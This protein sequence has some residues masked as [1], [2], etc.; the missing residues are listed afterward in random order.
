MIVLFKKLNIFINIFHNLINIIIK[1][2]MKKLLFRKLA[3][4]LILCF[5]LIFFV[6]SSFGCSLNPNHI[7]K[8]LSTYNMNLVFDETNF[9][10]NGN[11]Q[12]NFKNNTET[13]LNNLHFNLYPNAFRE[14]SNQKVI[15]LANKDKCYYNG[16]S[17]GSIKIEKVYD[18]QNDDLT[19]EVAGEDENILI[20]ELKN[21]V[22]PQ[23]NTQI[24]IS[25]EVTIP[26]ANH[27]FG[28]GENTV[29]LGNFFLIL[30]VYE[31]GCWQDMFYY[32]NGDPFY[33]E[34]SNFKVEIEY[35]NSYI[36]ASTG[37][38][39]DL[40]KKDD[41]KK[42]SVITAN[43][44]RDFAIVMSK[45]FSVLSDKVGKTT[46]SYY[47]YN[48]ENKQKS[49]QVCLNAIS[50]YNNLFGE[51]PYPEI[52]IVEANFVHGGMEYPNIVLI[53]DDI[54]DYQSYI[55]C[56]AHEL[57]HQWWYG[58]VGNNQTEYAWLDEGL[59]EYS[60]ALFFENHQEYGLNMDILVERA[61]SSY[62]VFQ[63]I[64]GNVLGNIDTTINRSLEK[65]NTEPEY[66]YMVYVQ[67]FLMFQT[68]NEMIGD[69]LMFA[70]LR[71]YFEDYAF[72]IAKPEDLIGSFEKTTH[73]NLE[74]YFTNYLNGKVIEFKD[75]V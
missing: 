42:I 56:I 22:A 29:N 55:Y 44:V 16:I 71:N 61:N 58:V 72:K 39:N 1:L 38:E 2:N 4:V 36:L 24:F 27:R 37:Q 33:S 75:K 3:K 23:N 73:A 63:T 13:I 70:S 43:A 50:T 57:A 30:C 14:N 65:F 9:I 51:Y 7:A 34:A 8:N 41:G 52:K 17:Y 32:S 54:P 15:S 64:Y 69:K 48:D 5:L 74:T 18:Q 20:V 60:T 11:L 28:Y 45:N 10:L 46:V 62:N 40:I 68:L 12:L 53:S 35:P 47:S 49:L 25:F 59:T 21:S 67:G 31:N 6:I 66:F 26:N 19:Y